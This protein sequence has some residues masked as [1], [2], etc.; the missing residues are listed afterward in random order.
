MA[1]KPPQTRLDT[2]PA[3]KGGTA[4]DRFLNEAANL[5]A[6]SEGG[7]GRL[8]FA[9]DA[10]MSRQPTWDMAAAHQGA[11]FD[12]AAGRGGLRVRLAFFRGAGE[13]RATPWI[14][15]PHRLQTAMSKVGCRGGRTQIG[16][17]LDWALRE[18]EAEPLA[19]LVFVGDAMEENPD[20]LCIRAG[21]LGLRGVP[22][23]VFHEGGDAMAGATF[24][25]I[26]RLS[27]GAYAPF[28]EGSADRLRALMEA[29]AAY[30]AGG[31]KALK[32]EAKRGGA[33]AGLLEQ[34]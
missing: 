15:D 4:V 12:A 11:M 28:G 18:A 16:R 7:R 26:A 31:R 24:K 13:F 20:A 32:L 27:K 3:S 34:L 1:R 2:A 22:V 10:T 23:F 29:V 6:P 21:E 14:G 17:V 9:L 19:G 25:E 30:A 8:L 33:A 5:P